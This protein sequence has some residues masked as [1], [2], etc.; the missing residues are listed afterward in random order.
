MSLRKAKHG[1]Q[2]FILSV[3]QSLSNNP[4][5]YIMLTKGS[6]TQ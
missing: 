1:F 5:L 4:Q 2:R 3:D 6:L